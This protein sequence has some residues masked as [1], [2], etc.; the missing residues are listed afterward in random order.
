MGQYDTNV[1]LT[2]KGAEIRMGRER[3]MI[4]R[5]DGIGTGHGCPMAYIAGALGS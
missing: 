5:R 1:R 4:S 3:F 2:D